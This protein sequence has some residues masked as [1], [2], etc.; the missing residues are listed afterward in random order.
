MCIKIKQMISRFAT[1]CVVVYKDGKLNSITQLS[2]NYKQDSSTCNR[3]SIDVV[4]QL[5]K[6]AKVDKLVV[7]FETRLK[8]A[9]CTACAINRVS[10]AKSI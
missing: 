7:G 8:T 5:P 9:I 1:L 4:I 6:T 10:Q 3:D 2:T